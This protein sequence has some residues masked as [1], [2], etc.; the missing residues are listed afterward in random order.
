MESSHY[1]HYCSLMMWMVAW[2]VHVDRC[3]D[4]GDAVS[5]V[6]VPTIVASHPIDRVLSTARVVPSILRGVS[7]RLLFQR[8][9]D[10]SSRS[11]IV[12]WPVHR[13]TAWPRMISVRVTDGTLRLVASHHASVR[14][15]DRR[16]IR[17]SNASDDAMPWRSAGRH[18]AITRQLQD[19]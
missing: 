10:H 17:R 7:V 19:G 2:V 4:G 14:R 5:Y 6:A 11:A 1:Y 12:S 16:T 9:I 18:A 15:Y 3:V 8:S 13:I